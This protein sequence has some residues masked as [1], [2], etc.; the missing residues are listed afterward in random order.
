MQGSG[1]M[2]NLYLIAWS[3]V[4]GETP[5]RGNPWTRDQAGS[6][7]CMLPAWGGTRQSR[8]QTREAE[9]MPR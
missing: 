9:V 6:A 8:E 4:R 5:S 3:L 1:C 7:E 2:K